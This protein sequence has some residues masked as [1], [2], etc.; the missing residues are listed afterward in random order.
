MISLHVHYCLPY[1][2][3]EQGIWAGD[4]SLSIFYIFFSPFDPI[5]VVHTKNV[6]I[7]LVKTA[8]IFGILMNENLKSKF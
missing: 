5:P 1:I 3:T 4:W 7:S 2:Y 8:I 6:L